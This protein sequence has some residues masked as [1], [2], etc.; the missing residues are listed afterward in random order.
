[1]TRLDLFHFLRPLWLLGLPVIGL[2]W[3]WARRR[4]VAV[5]SALGRLVAPHLRDALT[6]GGARARRLRPVDFASVAAASLTLAAAGPTWSRQPSPWLVETAP[7]VIA[8]EVSLSMLANDVQ[9]TR[10]DRAR[11]AI[12]DLIAARRGARTAVIAYASD[13][14]LVLPPTQDIEIVRPFLEGL[15]PRV[16]P[17]DGANASAAVAVAET[18]LNEGE[19]G[20]AAGATLLFV[21]DGFDAVDLP[22][23]AALEA[24]DGGPAMLALVFGSEEGGVA[25]MPDGSYATTRDGRRVDS[26][27]DT[28]ALRRFEREAGGMVVRASVDG[29]DIRRLSRRIESRLEQARS[30]DPNVRWNDRGW[31]FV[32]PAAAIAAGW[33][34]RGW[35]VRW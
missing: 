30:D 13:A 24:A 26:R 2:A 27:V 15:S 32:W 18:I 25:L 14:H 6:V 20:R 9:P 17:G 21:C 35:M 1:M 4:A 34:R 12:L 29:R 22:A 28:A 31:W 23:I 8:L 19:G 7:L 33:F 11:F 10:L 3:W 5:A 16:M